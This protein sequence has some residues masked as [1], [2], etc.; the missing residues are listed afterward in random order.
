MSAQSAIILDVEATAIDGAAAFIEEPMAPAN[1]KDPKTIATYIEKAKAEQLDKCALDIDLARIVAIGVQGSEYAEPV[2][3]PCQSEREE[4]AALEALWSI[5]QPYPFP[6]LIG[7]NILAYD[8]PLL[9]RRSFYLGV[10]A[11]PIQMG[12]YRHPDIV[13]LMLTWNFDGLVRTRSLAFVCK[14]LGIVVPDGI[15][16]AEVPGAIAAGR[17]EDVIAH[18][19]AD[20]ER[21]ARIAERL[22]LFTRS[23]PVI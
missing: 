17:W 11:P 1:Y 8:L 2:I 19:R 23:E 7:W 22:G 10:S 14:R 6:R 21:M 16:G 20:V 4:K 3:Y 18:A 9:L 12:K 13:D 5:V 15:N